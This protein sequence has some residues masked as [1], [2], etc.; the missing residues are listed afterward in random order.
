MIEDRRA[1]GQDPAEGSR[2]TAEHE[3]QRDD[4]RSLRGEKIAIPTPIEPGD[5]NAQ[6][7]P[8]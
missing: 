4:Q 2:K 6:S 8:S 1:P 7:T 3:L 5:Q